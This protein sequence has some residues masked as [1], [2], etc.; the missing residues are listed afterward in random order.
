MATKTRTWMGTPQRPTNYTPWHDCDHVDVC[1]HPHI[2][3][4]ALRTADGRTVTAQFTPD[5]ADRYAEQIASAAGFARALRESLSGGSAHSNLPEQAQM[6]HAAA[7]DAM[8]HD[9]GA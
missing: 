2:V 7:K 1:R 3:E 5:E 6:I 8:R 9:S 4:I